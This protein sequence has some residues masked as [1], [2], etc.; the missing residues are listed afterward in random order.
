M[1][2][3]R[4]SCLYLFILLIAIVAVIFSNMNINDL[5]LKILSTVKNW[6][7]KSVDVTNIKGV[8]EAITHELWDSL[9][10][11]NVSPDGKVN[12][13]GFDQK[14][15]SLQLYLKLLSD[16]PPNPK[17]WSEPEQLAYWINAYNAFT[18][19]LILQNYP[20]TSIRKHCGQY[21][22]DKFSMGSEIL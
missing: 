16:N 13:K 15:D 1:K 2:P 8:D 22:D 3:K 19:E 17:M 20:L 4:K 10:K 5:G 11:Q 6:S 21:S 7:Q 14:R 18:V 12:Y 9:L